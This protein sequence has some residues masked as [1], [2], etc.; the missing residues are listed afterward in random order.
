MP[1]SFP[2]LLFYC[3]GGCQFIHIR[4]EFLH[5]SIRKSKTSPKG[6]VFEILYFRS[7]Q[8]F[9]N[10]F[11]VVVKN[12]RFEFATRLSAELICG[13]APTPIFDWCSGHHVYNCPK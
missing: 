6:E 2:F 12:S 5:D 9:K 10:G 11:N 7:P 8:F 1:L 3:P 13:Q 4:I